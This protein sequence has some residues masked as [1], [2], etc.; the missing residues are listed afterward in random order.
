M[1][2]FLVILLF[3]LLGS[4]LI[5]QDFRFSQ[6]DLNPLYLNPAYAGSVEDTRI[7]GNYRNQWFNVPGKTLPGPLSS[8]NISFDKRFANVLIGGLGFNMSQ[9]YKGE[10]FYKHTHVG[11]SYSYHIPTKNKD[12]NLYIGALGISF[13]SLGVD[14]SRLVFTDQIDF[15]GG[16]LSTPSSFIPSNEGTRRYLDIS[17]GIVAKGNMGKTVSGEFSFSVNHL[18]T[19]NISLIQQEERLSRKYTSF[20]SL[21]FRLKKNKVYLNPKIMLEFQDPF[22]TFTLGANFYITKRYIYAN[23]QNFSKPLYFGVY[24]QT[25]TFDLINTNSMILTLGH[26][27]RIGSNN[28]RYQVGLSGDINVGGLN[29][30]SQ[31]TGELSMN[32]I[33]D[34]KNK[35]RNPD[36]KCPLFEGGNPLSPF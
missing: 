19:P 36:V 13:N 33:F 35:R 27:G 30:Q 18:N 5:A 11:L 16:Y 22:K 29:E 28:T 8:Y 6:F 32:I 24:F 17:S 10:G 15:Q 21:S 23:R 14:Y 7:G 2:Y 1:K 34:T 25:S 4:D 31:M 26:T 20:G 9:S 12:F 3:S